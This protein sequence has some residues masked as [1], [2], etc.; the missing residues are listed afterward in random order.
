MVHDTLSNQDT[1]FT[2]LTGGPQPYHHGDSLV[3]HMPWFL[4]KSVERA[5]Y[6]P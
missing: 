6:F 3:H 1:D 5:V 4:D 2:G